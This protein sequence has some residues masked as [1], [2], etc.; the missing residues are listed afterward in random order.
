MTDHRLGRAD[1]QT[2]GVLTEDAANRG[3][4]SHVASGRRGA[5][6]VD[7][8]HLIGVDSGV[9]QRAAHAACGAGTVVRRRGHVKRIS[10]HAET[11]DLG[12]DR[13]TARLACSSSS[14]TNAPAPSESTKPSRSRSHGRLAAAGSSLRVDRARAA[15]K[16]PIP[17]PQAAIS[18]P[19]ATM[20]SASPYAMFRA[21]MPM[22]CVPVVQAVAMA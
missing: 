8:L 1:R 18:E 13:R 22:Q 9:F 19:P 6:S 7:V 4:L 12:V 2:I 17:R 14:R 5:M 3:G 16:P 11:D 15:A 21:A 20:T 10:T